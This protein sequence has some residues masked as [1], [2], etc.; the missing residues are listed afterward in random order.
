MP[1]T[2]TAHSTHW[3]VS[4]AA[5]RNLYFTTRGPSGDQN[6]DIFVAPFDGQTY[7]EAKPLGPGVNTSATEHCPYIA[8]D[9][10]YLIFTRNDEETGNRDLYIA[11]RTS[12]GSWSEAAPLPS[13]INSRHTEIYPVVSPD[14]KYLFFLSWREGAGRI[15]WVEAD[16]LPPRGR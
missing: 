11:Y 1:S 3:Q 7:L 8:P 10:S 6:A 15:F 5:N 12:E 4:V 9:E 13:P 16:F 2:V 14:E